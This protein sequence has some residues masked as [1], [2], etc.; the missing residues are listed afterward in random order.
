LDWGIAVGARSNARPYRDANVAG[1]FTPEALATVVRSY[2]DDLALAA[3][4]GM[5]VGDM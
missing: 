2:L 4:L 5:R 1:E 3:A